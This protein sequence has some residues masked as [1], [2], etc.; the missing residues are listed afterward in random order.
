MTACILSL[1]VAPGVLS[2]LSECLQ[3]EVFPAD[4]L[5]QALSLLKERDFSSIL[6]DS[7]TCPVSD[8]EVERVLGYTSPTTQIVLLDSGRSGPDCER[9]ALL[10]IRTMKSPIVIDELARQLFH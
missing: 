9:L 4:D 1:G 6:V 8:D 3:V 5:E 2:K 7:G 10:G